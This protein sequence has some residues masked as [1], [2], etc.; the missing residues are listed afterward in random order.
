MARRLAAGLM[1]VEVNVIALKIEN[2]ARQLRASKLAAAAASLKSRS[3]IDDA[4]FC[5]A[6]MTDAARAP[7]PD[8][9]ARTL[10]AK[11]AL[12]LRDYD[13]PDRE[14]LAKR[15]QSICADRGVLFLVGGDRALAEK[16]GA[17][18]A[19]FPAWMTPESL[20]PMITSA[21]CHNDAE[22]QRAGDAKVDLALVSPVF[23]TR[24]HPGQ[25]S[26]GADAFKLM[27]RRASIPVL[28]L[29]GVDETNVRQLA[30]PNV[31]GFAAISAFLPR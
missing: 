21:A 10:P 26:L 23:Q 18:G 28:A 6:F 30:G 22:I 27:A 8:I 1:D 24:S 16:I 14:A 17:D 11:A 7:D 9:V 29:G 2:E 31:A 5:L 20:S 25:Q 13:A 19:H 12:I 3:D 15:L 4:A